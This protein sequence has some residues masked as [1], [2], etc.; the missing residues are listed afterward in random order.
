MGEAK[1]IEYFEKINWAAKIIHVAQ[2]SWNQ[3]RH[4][5][6]LKSKIISTKYLK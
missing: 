4:R 2:I 3:W 5:N 6:D 1:S